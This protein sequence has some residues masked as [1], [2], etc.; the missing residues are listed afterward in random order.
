MNIENEDRGV[1]RARNC[2]PSHLRVEI[3]LRLIDLRN[4]VDRRLDPRRIEDGSAMDRHCIDDR[5]LVR[6]YRFH[7]AEAD[8]TDHR[9]F[10]YDKRKRDGIS[11]LDGLGVNVFEKTHP[12]DRLDVAIDD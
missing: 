10:G 7:L 4:V 2:A 11:V 8:L 12:V 9:P 1:V 3:T 5:L 6:F